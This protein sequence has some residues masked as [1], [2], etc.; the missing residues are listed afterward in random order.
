M[1]RPE[2]DQRGLTP[3]STRLK[4]LQYFAFAIILLGFKL[5]T[6]KYYGNSTPFWD[7]WDGEAANLY[8]PFIDGNLGWKE[9]LSAHN[10]HRIFTTRLL[11]LTLLKINILWNPLLQMVV[12]AGFHICVIILSIHLLLKITGRKYL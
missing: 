5:R 6:I 7:Q 1:K 12:N 4:L 3:I 11:D 9:L 10:E 2:K 8:K